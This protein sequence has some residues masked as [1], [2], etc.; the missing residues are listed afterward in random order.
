MDQKHANLGKMKGRRNMMRLLWKSP[1]L[2]DG[3]Q[4]PDGDFLV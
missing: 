4:V 1:S 3:I 2:P